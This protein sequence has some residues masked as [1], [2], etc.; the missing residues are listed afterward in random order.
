MGPEL[1]SSITIICAIVLASSISSGVKY[2]T[3][4]KGLKEQESVDSGEILK[5]YF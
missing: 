1:D 2:L 5:F 4:F 3:S